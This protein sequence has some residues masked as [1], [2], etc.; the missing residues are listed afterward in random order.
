MPRA[1]GSGST[2]LEGIATIQEATIGGLTSH[3]VHF[4]GPG[5]VQIHAVS[6]NKGEGGRS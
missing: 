1:R 3:H 2:R 5:T 4:R 6:E